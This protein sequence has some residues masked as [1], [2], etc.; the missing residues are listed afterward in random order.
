MLAEERR[1]RLLGIAQ[2]KNISSKFAACGF[3][4][5]T[6]CPRLKQTNQWFTEPGQIAFTKARALGLDFRRVGLD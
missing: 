1:D 5:N 2:S 6:R 3:R 4:Y